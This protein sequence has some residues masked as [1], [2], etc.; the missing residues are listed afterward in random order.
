M[1]AER[2]SDDELD[3]LGGDCTPFVQ[4][5]RCIHRKA[6]ELGLTAA[7]R[8]AWVD[9]VMAADFRTGIVGSLTWQATADLLG[10]SIPTAKERLGTLEDRGL[11]RYRF[12][13]GHHGYVAVVSYLDVVRVKHP[14]RTEAIASALAKAVA[15][16]DKAAARTQAATQT[17]NG[18]D[19]AGNSTDNDEDLWSDEG[20]FRS[21]DPTSYAKEASERAGEPGPSTAFEP[22][23][24]SFASTAAVRGQSRR[25]PSRTRTEATR[26]DRI[27][28]YDD[29]LLGEH[30]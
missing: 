30:P 14:G 23:R 8:H 7:E 15:D 27:R 10:C 12:T 24:P 5:C 17:R 4:L 21:E 25:A 18:A 22:V 26:S 20:I 3:A 16:A 2:L 11:I 6:D 9:L 19:R 13:R 29:S 1:S 28:A